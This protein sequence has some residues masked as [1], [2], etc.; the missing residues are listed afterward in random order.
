MIKLF[1][2]VKGMDENWNITFE[3]DENLGRYWECLPGLKQKR[4]FAK[5]THLREHVKI[6]T[7]NDQSL[8]LLRTSTRGPKVMSNIINY[9]TLSN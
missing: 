6:K 5:E 1:K 8:E 2:Q 7:L 4:W 3:I 9:D